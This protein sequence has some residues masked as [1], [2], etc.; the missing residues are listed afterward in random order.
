MLQQTFYTR[1]TVMKVS[2]KIINIKKNL[3]QHINRPKKTEVD[4]ARL[5]EKENIHFSPEVVDCE[6][7]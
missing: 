4:K 7:Q 2:G 3:K 6:S 1:I 5:L